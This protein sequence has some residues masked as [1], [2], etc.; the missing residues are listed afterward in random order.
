MIA[1]KKKKTKTI[2]IAFPRLQASNQKGDEVT[3][4]DKHFEF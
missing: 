4:I 2:Q 1:I 3:V